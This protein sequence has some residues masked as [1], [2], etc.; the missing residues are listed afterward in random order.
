[1]TRRLE[2]IHPSVLDN[3]SSSFIYSFITG[4]T[5]YIGTTGAERPE[6]ISGR[7]RSAGA[8]GGQR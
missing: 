6:G 2:Y 4:T 8:K 5:R 1:M 3:R 7:G